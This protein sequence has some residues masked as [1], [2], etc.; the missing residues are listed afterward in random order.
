[1]YEYIESMRYIINRL[2][3]DTRLVNDVI[4]SAAHAQTFEGMLMY[5]ACLCPN[6]VSVHFYAIPT[7]HFK[8]SKEEGESILLRC[9]PSYNPLPDS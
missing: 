1:M 3:N 2:C 8:S 7:L 4:T 9:A 5:I 6:L